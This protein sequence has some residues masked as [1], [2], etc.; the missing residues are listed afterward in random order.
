MYEQILKVKGWKSLRK[1]PAN[2]HRCPG[3]G[4]FIEMLFHTGN[5][6]A[7]CFGCDK[8]FPVEEFK[9]V[10][11]EIDIALC[12]ECDQELPLTDDSLGIVGYKCTCDNYVAVPF[13]NQLVHPQEILN[14]SWNG[15]LSTR[16][17]PASEKC[18][19]VKCETARDWYVLAVLQVLAKEG[20]GEFKFA[21]SE[22][23]QALLALDPTHTAYVGY[24]L[25][26][27]LAEYSMLNQ[28]YVRSEHRR[29]G[30]AETVV[31][32]WAK[33]HA[34]LKDGKFALE[35]PNETAF[36]LHLKLGHIRKEGDLYV[37]VNCF[38]MPAGF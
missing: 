18:V 23:N 25:W 9:V 5:N 2:F 16:G 32:H 13:E 17:K 12:A 36:A 35:S 28:L 3:C 33:N 19:V 20:N 6:C 38:V 11:R 30:Y 29:R 37:G 27:D 31:T 4:E 10:Q 21:D 1:G 34:R 8:D 22:N 24:L 26:Y 14:P 15:D 7:T